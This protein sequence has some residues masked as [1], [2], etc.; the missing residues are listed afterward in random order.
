M[1]IS[2]FNGVDAIRGIKEL[3]RIAAITVV[4]LIAAS[5]FKDESDIRQFIVVLL[6]SLVV[7]FSFGIYQ[8][9]AHAGHITDPGYY[10]PPDQRYHR[11]MGTFGHPVPYAM[12]INFPLLLCLAFG[13]DSKTHIAKRLLFFCVAA[14]LCL[15]LFWTYTRSCWFG[16]IVATVFMGIRKNK[17]LLMLVPILLLLVL[18]YV[19]LKS[20]RLGE[21]STGKLT[22]SGRI[23]GH[24]QM[25]PMVFER[26]L[27]GHGLTSF[28]D[29][30]TQSDHLR[31]LLETG[32]LGYAAFLCLLMALYRAVTESYHWG[33][34][35]LEK[36]FFLAYM[37]Y[38][39]CVVVVG[40]SETN[41]IFQ[42]YVWVPG[43][44]VLAARF[45][46]GRE[47]T[48]AK[49]VGQTGDETCPAAP[50]PATR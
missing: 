16:M 25:L 9:V 18:V 47:E 30:T 21:F 39:A 49:P 12:F 50:G 20:I 14:P 19:P 17:T 46:R 36:N 33:N 45:Y 28:A 31:L 8:Q 48:N 40:F 43:G 23:E 1:A 24:K 34:S 7:P 44:I 6:L 29:F 15:T 4:Y 3:G 32:F 41:A 38:F 35:P 10:I 26:P 5:S 27:L 11:I 42:Y 22:F 2:I 13:L 37:A